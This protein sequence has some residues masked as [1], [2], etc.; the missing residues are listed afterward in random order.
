MTSPFEQ[1]SG[2][3]I[4]DSSAENK[5]KKNET[6]IEVL[7]LDKPD[8]RPWG[9]RVDQHFTEQHWWNLYE[10]VVKQWQEEMIDDIKSDINTDSLT[11]LSE[12]AEKDLEYNVESMARRE[13]MRLLGELTQSSM[14]TTEM[15]ALLIH[16]AEPFGYEGIKAEIDSRKAS[17]KLGLKMGLHQETPRDM[18]PKEEDREYVTRAKL[19]DGK[20]VPLNNIVGHVLNA[21]GRSGIQEAVRKANERS[22]DYKALF[23]KGC[24]AVA[25]AR[26]RNTTPGGENYNAQ[27]VEI[28]RDV[29]F[30]LDE[31]PENGSTL[32]PDE[33]MLRR[34]KIEE[35]LPKYFGEE[36]GSVPSKFETDE[37]YRIW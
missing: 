16:G 13:T 3:A 19:V 37:K 9:N 5:D 26:H 33:M 7:K 23:L 12:D 15:A 11:K 25:D 10:D 22:A 8:E 4:I 30:G 24:A 6:G 14:S 21:T 27:V 29:S 1:P 31:K 20:D 18:L 34:A 32:S 36:T 35:A 17:M 28:M 2:G